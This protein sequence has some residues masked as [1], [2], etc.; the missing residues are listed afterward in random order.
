MP[1]GASARVDIARVAPVQLAEG[2]PQAA[3]VRRREYD[4]DVIGQQAIG[5]YFG[6]R[7]L[8]RG[9]QKIEVERVIAVLEERALAAVAALRDVV[10]DAG[11]DDAR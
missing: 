6:L 11:D 3:F 7:P 1:G 8:C 5:P 9:G 10:G 4:V 2:T